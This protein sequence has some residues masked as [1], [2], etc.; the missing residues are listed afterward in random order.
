MFKTSVLLKQLSNNNFKNARD[1]ITTFNK[2]F[3]ISI[4]GNIGCGKSTLLKY[5]NK[6]SNIKIT[7]VIIYF[8]Y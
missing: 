3:K 4:E 8:I 2:P 1:C 5:F 7:S 6:F